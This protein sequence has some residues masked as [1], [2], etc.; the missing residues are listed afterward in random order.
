MFKM[1]KTQYVE[2]AKTELNTRLNNHRKKVIGK[3]SIPASNYFDTEG[4]D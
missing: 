1:L 4:H 3:D 2:K